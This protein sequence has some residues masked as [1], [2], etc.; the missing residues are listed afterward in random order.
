[1]TPPAQRV[2]A[3]IAEIADFRGI[4]TEAAGPDQIVAEGVSAI[5]GETVLQ[6]GHIHAA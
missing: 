5:Q 4:G 3:T 2:V 1:M 6:G